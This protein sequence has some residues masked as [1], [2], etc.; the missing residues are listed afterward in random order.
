MYKF[1]R[2]VKKIMDDG[3]NKKYGKKLDFGEKNYKDLGDKKQ[4]AFDDMS[5]DVK[6]KLRGELGLQV[7]HHSRDGDLLREQREIEQTLTR[8]QKLA[9]LK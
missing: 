9:G 7:S 6:N 5:K 4:S 1:M 2:K 8:W 3:S